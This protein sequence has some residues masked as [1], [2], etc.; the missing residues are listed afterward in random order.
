LVNI[1]YN[2]C[3]RPSDAVYS[4]KLPACIYAFDIHN[5][6]KSPSKFD[7]LETRL[8]KRFTFGS[9][10]FAEFTR[11]NVSRSTAM[12]SPKYFSQV[13]L[14]ANASFSSLFT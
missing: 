14:W 7:R 5:L 9:S 6:G 12:N 2:I 4:A 1:D 3:H 13:L 11:T 8:Q 10:E